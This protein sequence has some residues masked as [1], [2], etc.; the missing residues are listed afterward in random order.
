MSGPV[1]ARREL[2]R[3][4]KAA[5]LPVCDPAVPG[6]ARRVLVMVTGSLPILEALSAKLA[7]DARIFALCPAH[8][9]EAVK[10]LFPAMEKLWT[11]TKEGKLTVEGLGPAL[12][13]AA[14]LRYDLALCLFNDVRGAGYSN[15]EEIAARLPGDLALCAV[16]CRGELL[17]LDR[18]GASERT[19][20]LA[21]LRLMADSNWASLKDREQLP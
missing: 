21:E 14:S 9:A 20:A 3:L 1:P 2:E 6:N 8:L 19:S 18:E 10:A 17:R 15:V 13:E 12:A 11:Q 16:N 5:A 7:P 4:L